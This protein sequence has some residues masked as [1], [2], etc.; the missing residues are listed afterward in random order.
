[1]RALLVL[2]LGVAPALCPAQTKPWGCT[3][4]E[5]VCAE[6]GQNSNR[7]KA[8]RDL[9]RSQCEEFWT[10]AE[11]SGSAALTASSAGTYGSADREGQNRVL[12]RQREAEQDRRQ[13]EEQRRADQQAAFQE[14]MAEAERVRQARADENAQDLKKADYLR[15]QIEAIQKDM[16]LANRQMQRDHDQLKAMIDRANSTAM[17][18]QQRAQVSA[19]LRSRR[20]AFAEQVK[21]HEW[22]QQQRQHEIDDLTQQYEQIRRKYNQGGGVP[23]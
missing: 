3:R 4:A 12:Q 9:F 7:C 10:D 18:Q 6:A 5:Q 23:R 21:R 16:A 17:S 22:D 14:Q 8:Q 1:M 2:A 11:S 20:E 13:M 15:L 19:D